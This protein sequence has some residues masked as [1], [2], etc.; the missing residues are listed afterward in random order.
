MDQPHGAQW[1]FLT[2]FMGSGKSTLGK[3]L[4]DQLSLPFYDTDEL[5]VTDAGMSIRDIFQQQGEKAFRQLEKNKLEHL[6]KYS[7]PGVVATGGGVVIDP[8]NRQVMRRNG[9]VIWLD[10]PL[11]LLF[12]HL[13]MERDKRP[14]LSHENWEQ[15]ALQTY[16]DRIPFYLQCHFKILNGDDLST[17]LSSIFQ[18]LNLTAT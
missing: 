16:R 18:K 2:G 13:R 7:R 9:T 15:W 4:A 17:S 11:S 12:E 14:L 10:R 6:V 8:I 5:I 1:I 3:V